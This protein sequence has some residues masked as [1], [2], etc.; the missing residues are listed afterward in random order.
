MKYFGTNKM[1]SK[2][3][4]INNAGS[5]GDDNDNDN[6]DSHSSGNDYWS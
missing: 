2:L 5:K 4:Q 3:D 6:G 1:R